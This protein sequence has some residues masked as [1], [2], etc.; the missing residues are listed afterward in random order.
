[1]YRNTHKASKMRGPSIS[2]ASLITS[3]AAGKTSHLH[4]DILSP[5]S[6]AAGER[7]LRRRDKKPINNA[8]DAETASREFG[9]RDWR[10]HPSSTRPKEPGQKGDR[11]VPASDDGA[12]E[13][14]AR[15]DSKVGYSL[16]KH[17]VCKAGGRSR[18][19][20]SEGRSGNRGAW[21]GMGLRL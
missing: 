17:S 3:H 16:T 1:M 8:S 6:G 5:S 9:S 12:A 13:Q 4:P 18:T 2:F 20:D 7:R 11:V 19:V 21:G 10:C 14:G 15:S